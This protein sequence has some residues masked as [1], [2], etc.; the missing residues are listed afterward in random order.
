ME[1]QPDRLAPR[2]DALQTSKERIAAGYGTDAPNPMLARSWQRC[3]QAGLSP[4]RVTSDV[5]HLNGCELREAQDRI[6]DLAVRARPIIEYL[7]GQIRDSGCIILLS[8]E[9]GI[10]LDAVGDPGFSG[11]AAQVALRPGASWAETDRGTNAVG[12]ALVEAAP[13]VIH[14]SEHFLDRNGFLACAAAPLTASNGHLIGV[15]DISCDQRVYHPHTF[16]LVRAAAQMIENRMFEI[17]HV[18]DIKLRFHASRQGVGTLVEGVVAVTADGRIRGANG[19]AMNLLGLH[20]RD[21]GQVSVSPLFDETLDS[22]LARERRRGGDPLELHRAGGERVFLRVD[23]PRV[24]RPASRSTIWPTDALASLE[25]GDPQMARAISMA[26]RAVGRSIPILVHGE[27]GVGKDVMA[28]AIHASGTRRGGPFVAVNCAALP[29]SMIEAELFGYAPG[30][31]TGARREGSPGRIREAEGGTLFLDEIG[32]MPLSMQTRLLRVLEERVVSPLG[33]RPVPVDFSLLSATNCDLRRA[34]AERRFRADLYYRISGLG[35]AIPPLRKRTDLETLVER[36]LRLE[37]GDTL[38]M[39]APDL[40]AAFRTYT[41]P[42][43]VRQLA[44][45]LR[46][47][48]SLCDPEDIEI[49]WRHLP[50]DIV[51]ELRA[52]PEP[53]IEPEMRNSPS[54]SLRA[55]SDQLILRTIEAAGGNMSAAARLLGISRNTLYRRV[56]LM[57]DRVGQ[58]DARP[59]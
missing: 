45:V 1:F 22:L 24:A 36:I 59:R 11:R 55:H 18:R 7:H 25:T 20:Q 9:N 56:A 14:G 44:N 32:D 51:E 43:N 17:A 31:F 50:D 3:V 5:P 34:V 37:S 40:L 2:H 48:N 26:R 21:L 41:W 54:P 39:L 52:A 15:L 12:T 19:P 28:R 10:L 42:G 4:D 16:G 33:G 57:P 47:G 29:E 30:A 8:D 27:T 46:I 58:D 13:V 38:R 6:A 49:S 53:I 35:I 23:M